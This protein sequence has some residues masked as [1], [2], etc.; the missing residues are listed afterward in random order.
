MKRRSAF[1]L[2]LLALAATLG[3]GC[4]RVRKT[5]VALPVVFPGFSFHWVAADSETRARALDG[6]PAGF[7]TT[8]DDWG[9][10]RAEGQDV[11]ST[12]LRS[13]GNPPDGQICLIERRAD[14]LY[15]PVFVER[16]PAFRPVAAVRSCRAETDPFDRNV[17]SVVLGKRDAET[18]ADVT[19]AGDGASGRRLALVLG[20]AVLCAPFVREPIR[21]G[22]FVV[23]GSFTTAEAA[24]LAAILAAADPSAE[25]SAEPA[26]AS[27][28]WDLFA[29]ISSQL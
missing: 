17:V 27:F 13:F 9:F 15:G 16:E 6:V 11:D 2:P 7:R 12:A 24:F 19:S 22:R 25:P 21:D 18:F 26:S 14:G 3:A 29:P 8:E 10:I 4:F 5:A 28:V 20:D 1:L 23:S